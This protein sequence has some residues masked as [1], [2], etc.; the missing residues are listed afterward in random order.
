MLQSLSAFFVRPMPADGL[1]PA[2]GPPFTAQ[3]ALAMFLKRRSFCAPL[4][5]P[6]AVEGSGEARCI[7]IAYGI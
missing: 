6:V 3:I 1:P 5:P 2:G 7:R 4:P